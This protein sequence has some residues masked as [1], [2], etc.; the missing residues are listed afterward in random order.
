MVSNF[1]LKE[2]FFKRLK[3][4]SVTATTIEILVRFKSKRENLRLR[5]RK[6]YNVRE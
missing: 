6:G 4:E 5:I 1:K 3:Q 2:S